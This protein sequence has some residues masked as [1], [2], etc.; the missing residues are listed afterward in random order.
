MNYLLVFLGGGVGAVARY[1]MQAV[2]YRTLGASFP[3]G[4]L[5]VNVLGSFSIGLLMTLVESRLA[6]SPFLRVF[7]AIGVLGGFTTFSSFSYETMALLRDSN[8][9]LGLAN[10]GSNVIMCFS[11][12]WIGMTMGKLL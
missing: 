10:I 6:I 1:G 4:T 12:T 7:L 9:A 3:Y 2:V 11:A 5:L 8:Y